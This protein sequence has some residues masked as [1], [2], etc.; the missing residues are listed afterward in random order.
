MSGVAMS[1]CNVPVDPCSSPVEVE[2][3]RPP[4]Q[5]AAHHCKLGKG[6][7]QSN[8]HEGKKDP[9]LGCH[10]VRT[11]FL[12]LYLLS[13]PME[14]GNT[15]ETWSKW[16]NWVQWELKKDHERPSIRLRMFA[17]EHPKSLVKATWENCI[18]IQWAKKEDV[19]C[20]K[21]ENLR[22]EMQ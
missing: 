2:V 8:K 6:S 3:E 22:T 11:S 1:M 14:I 20:S 13:K 12:N 9:K 15:S 16:I 18:P 17:A 10:I 5:T 21:N 7:F 19:R 4:G